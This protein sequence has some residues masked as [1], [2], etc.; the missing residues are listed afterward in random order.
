MHKTG[1][2][3]HRE[4]AYHLT[5]DAPALCIDCHDV[6]EAAI[7]KAHH[8]QP[9]ETADCI[10]CHDARQSNSP[11]LMQAFLHSPFES[12]E[13]DDCHQPAKNGKVV[14]TQK[15]VKSTCAVCH[16]EQAKQIASAKVP[17]PGAQNDCTVCHN[18]HGGMSPGFL[19][20]NPVQACLACHPKRAEEFKKKHLHQPASDLGCATCHEPHGG[21]NAH[22]LRAKSVNVLCLECHGPDANPQ[23]VEG[24]H[25]VAIFD[26][27]VKLPENYFNKV[28]V[29]PLKYGLGHPT[30]NHPVGDALIPKTK[31]VFAMNC[32]TCHQPHAGNEQGMLVKD[33]KNDMNFCN[34]CHNNGM[35]LADIRT[36]G[37]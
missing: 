4:F 10:Q 7:V 24:Q 21:D 35:D 22:L 12:K 31:T 6:K 2:P 23:K 32:L 28:P 25:L 17:H 26:G 20:P 33:Q 29:L 5:K 16:E 9:F 14:L 37:K 36:G 30:E 15:D 27:K 19:Q 11:N 1:D 18:P 3:A 8:G 13:C 34:T